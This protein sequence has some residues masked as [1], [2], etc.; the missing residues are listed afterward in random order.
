MP[1]QVFA[2]GFDMTDAIRQAC[3]AEFKERLQPIGMQNVSA[4]FKLSL[5][6]GE[7]VAHV[8]WADGPYLG[9]ATSKSEDMYQS[10]R[11]SV[12][13]SAEQMKKTHSKIMERRKDGQE[14]IPEN[15]ND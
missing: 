6:K 5:E 9:D 10:I 8:A 1:V 15:S 13:K 12:K 14:E 7:H 11:L 4:K 3:E 2:Q